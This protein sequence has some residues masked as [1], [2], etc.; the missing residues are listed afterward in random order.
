MERNF[1]EVLE[2]YMIAEE[3]IR[4]TF[5]KWKAKYQAYREKKDIEKLLKKQSKGNNSVSYGSGSS[6]SDSYS[7]ENIYDV[8][9]SII[10][11][12]KALRKKEIAKQLDFENKQIQKL[13]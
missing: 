11:K 12:E 3:G 9:D 13:Q 6:Y 10:K 5:N 7:S 8:P 2:S 4:D 1:S